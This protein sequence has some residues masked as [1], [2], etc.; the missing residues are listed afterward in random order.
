ME[1]KRI[2][3]LSKT[4]RQP[5][6]YRPRDRLGRAGALRYRQGKRIFELN[7]HHFVEQ[8]FYNIMKCALCNDFLVNSGFQ[9]EGTYFSVFCLVSFSLIA[10]ARTQI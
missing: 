1:R 2:H 7:G 10:C 8:R 4:V 6:K 9:C 5:A 3:T